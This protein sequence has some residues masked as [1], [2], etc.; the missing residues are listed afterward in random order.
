MRTPTKNDPDPCR[1]P[2]RKNEIFQEGDFEDFIA[3]I[4]KT[5]DLYQQQNLDPRD[6]E[7]NYKSLDL[8]HHNGIDPIA[9]AIALKKVAD[10]NPDAGMEVLA[11]QGRGNQRIRLQAR[12]AVNADSSQLNDQYFKQYGELHN[13]QYEELQSILVSIAEKDEQILRLEN[14]IKSAIKQPKFYVETYQNQGEFIMSQSKGNVNISDVRGNV[15]GV[16]AAGENQTMTGVAIG[17][18]SGSVT[19]AIDRLTASPNLDNPGIKELLVQLQAAIE[20]ELELPDEDKAEALEQVKTLA[21]AGQKPEDSTLQK[22]AKTSMKI[23]K[24][25]VA[26]LPDAAKLAESC[27]KLLPAI[28]ALLA[29]G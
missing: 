20:A 4:I 11:L 21:E 10:Q 7:I 17:F 22:A 8:M 16:A 26:S 28:A 15:S 18:I 25:T 14:I 6:V 24:G 27:A 29:L 1:K 13:L 2:D 23:L 12:V 9:A 5:L 19:N 3:P